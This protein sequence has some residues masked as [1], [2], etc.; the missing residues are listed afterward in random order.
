M[1]RLNQILPLLPPFSTFYHFLHIY[2]IFP[3]FTTFCQLLSLSSFLPLLSIFT[4]LQFTLF[5]P[6]FTQIYHILSPLLLFT[7]FYHFL[8][9]F[10]TFITFY[11]FLPTF[12]HVYKT[13]ARSSLLSQNFPTT[14]YFSNLSLAFPF[15]ALFFC[16]C[17]SFYYLSLPP[18][19]H[20]TFSISPLFFL[21][22]RLI[23]PI[24]V[25]LF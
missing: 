20:I 23:Y 19:Y 2:H 22:L 10:A 8:L 1:C 4:N 24:T 9:N 25:L 21:S 12:A 14:H 16:S 6:L 3:N 15:H 13:G 7:S 18:T 17:F 5:L 11:H